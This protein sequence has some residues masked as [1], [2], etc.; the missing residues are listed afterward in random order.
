MRKCPLNNFQ[1]CDTDCSWYL[2]NAECCAIAKLN[3]LNC[4]DDLIELKA[5]ERSISSIESILNQ[6]Y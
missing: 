3:R 1:E 4:I 2:K 5:I 6:R